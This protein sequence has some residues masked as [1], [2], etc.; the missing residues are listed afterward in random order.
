MSIF[1]LER[2]DRL[3]R[4]EVKKFLIKL[5]DLKDYKHKNKPF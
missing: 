1:K 2:F 5:I 3:E 4:I